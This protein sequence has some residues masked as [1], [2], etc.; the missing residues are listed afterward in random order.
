MATVHGND[1]DNYAGFWGV[2]LV[3]SQ[4]DDFIYGYGGDDDLFGY[5]GDD[6]LDGGTGEDY[7]EGGDGNDSYILTAIAGPRYGRRLLRC[8]ISS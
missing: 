2:G 3:G 7:M 1:L 5:G 4:Y 8:G 6:W